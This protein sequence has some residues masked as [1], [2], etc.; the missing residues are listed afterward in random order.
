MAGEAISAPKKQQQPAKRVR[1]SPAGQTPPLKD[2]RRPGPQK[3]LFDSIPTATKNVTV[4]LA[5]G[6]SGTTRTS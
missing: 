6:D 1:G 5:G 3:R 2:K 4:E